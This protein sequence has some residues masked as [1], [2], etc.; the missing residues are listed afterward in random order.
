MQADMSL[1]LESERNPE[2]GHGTHILAWR[3]SWTEEPSRPLCLEE[4]WSGLL[5]PSPGGLPY[6][7]IE[8]T[9]SALAGEFYLPLAPLKS[10]HNAIEVQ[11]LGFTA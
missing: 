7:G 10:T 2:G 6:P 3:I 5:Y 4:Y 11:G 9:F 1:I 8:P